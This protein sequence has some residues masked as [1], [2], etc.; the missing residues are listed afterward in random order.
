[1]ESVVLEQDKVYIPQ[2]PFNNVSEYKSY[3][4][5]KKSRKKKRPENSLALM[6]AREKANKSIKKVSRK[7]DISKERDS[8]I[9][10]MTKYQQYIVGRIINLNML[11]NMLNENEPSEKSKEDFKEIDELLK[12]YQKNSQEI[13]TSIDICGRLHDDLTTDDA[14]EAITHLSVEIT[15]IMQSTGE[16]EERVSNL[17]EPYKDRLREY[18]IN[19]F[20]KSMNAAQAE[21]ILDVDNNAEEDN[22]TANNEEYRNGSET[23]AEEA[24]ETEESAG[25]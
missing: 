23:E 8:L 25:V 10:D 22:A 4:K 21:D 2:K 13:K 14:L 18:I 11:K 1:M 24:E 17:I 5:N 15:E 7:L 16:L 6:L 12:I 3:K 20:S 9:A 19:I